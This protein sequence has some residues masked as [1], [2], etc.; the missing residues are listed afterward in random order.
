MDGDCEILSETE[1]TLRLA[2]EYVKE[3]IVSKNF[4]GDARHIAVAT[5]HNVD[6]LVSWNFKHIVHFDKIRQFN[7]VNLREGYKPI[8]IY[9]P[10][11]VVSYE[12]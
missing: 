1:E 10:R 7:S 8:E 9:S 2:L 12:V 4:E 11:E 5:I 3:K 6:M